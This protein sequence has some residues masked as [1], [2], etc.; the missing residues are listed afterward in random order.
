[1]KKLAL[2]FALAAMFCIASCQKENNDG[3]NNGGGKNNDDNY[4]APIT[5]DG[6]F[7]DWAA[8]DSKV[9]TLNCAAGHPKPDL[10]MAKIY[11]DKYYVFIYVE[12]NFAAYDGV[13]GVSDA[14]FHFYINGDKDTSTGGYMGAFDQGDTPCVDVM[15]EG[16]VIEGGAVVQ[17]YDPTVYT[18]EGP[19]N[20]ADWND[21]YWIDQDLS[22]F[23][24]GKGTAKAFE[25]VFTRELYPAGKLANGFTM[26]MDICVNCWD[27]TGALPNAAP[28]E[29][30]AAGQAPLVTVNIVK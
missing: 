14:H 3:N 5:I 6:N 19:A 10:K 22:G 18:W 13:S 21:D 9:T 2:F 16:D 20:Y 25:F 4:V 29:T 28:T 23:V 17:A 27:A 7:E 26:G 11:A 1:M 12:F 30:N 8:I 15:L 24:E